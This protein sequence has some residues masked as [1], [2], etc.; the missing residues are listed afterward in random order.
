MSKYLDI[1]R[2]YWG[3]DSFR[4]IQEDIITSICEGN[5]TLGL[6]P[7][8]G[9]KSIC[10]QVPALAMDGLC[11][12][13]T[14]LISLMKDQVEHLRQLGIKAEAIYSGMFHD[15]IIRTLDNCTYGN[16]KLLYISPERLT[17]E[18]FRD[19]IRQI[20]KISMITVD[21]AHC[22]SQ[23]GYDF[24]PSYMKIPELRTL[25]PY[26]VPILALTATATKKV[27]IDI[28]QRLNFTDSRVFSM[29]FKRENLAYIVQ[30]SNDKASQILH[31]LKSYPEGS[32]IIYT[33][34]RATTKEISNYLIAN[35]ISADN[36][37]AGLTDAER[38]LRQINWTK[39]RNRVMVA[40]NAFGMGIDKADVR[41]VI[42]YN[43]PD[44]LEAYFQEA[45]RAGRDGKK[46]FAILL[47]D[48]HDDTILNKR[49]SDTYPNI[50]FIR[51]TYENVCFF[52]QI[53]EGEGANRTFKFGI[54][55][56]CNTF[57]Q[58]PVQT[59]SALKLLS[60]AGY[61][62]YQ[63][64]NTLKSRLRIILHKEDLYYLYHLDND[65]NSI[66]QALL[67]T[68]SGVF[69]DYIFIEETLIAQ[70]TNLT[71]ERV[72]LLLKE[73]SRQHI[74]DYIPQSNCPTISFMVPR[75]DKSR[76]ILS[77]HIYDDRKADF[78]KR[79][80]CMLDYASSSHICRSRLLL[81]YFD[82]KNTSDCGQCDVCIQNKEMPL[83]S[84]EKI[85]NDITTLLSDYKKHPITSLN[86]I[87]GNTEIIDF[88]IRYMV[89]E[90]IIKI[91]DNTIQLNQQ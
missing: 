27:I 78:A 23:W 62:K 66:I 3:F 21:E 40:T 8:G 85:A 33:R 61:I 29:S 47:Y 60:N 38:S 41:I 64:D 63:S 7:T 50:D 77:R 26:H 10:F 91:I 34:N 17:S 72:Y 44:S 81:H 19:R 59:D 89:D 2:K 56:F 76:I 25:I 20:R 55:Q 68:Y 22:I 46:A 18:T 16:Y 87:S 49:I 14:P 80:K 54:E 13:I 5:D 32:A 71:S 88:V 36:Y 11:L 83:D 53:G 28:Q 4:G 39:G 45:G 48:S 52:L 12:V 84:I 37:H 30:P 73:L 6:M 31:I 90:E 69:A 74:I 9:G 51:Q 43:I 65:T 86:T 24:R 42:H 15:D 82:E 67:R 75:I 79:I 58:F 57:K 70:L 35:G 1:L